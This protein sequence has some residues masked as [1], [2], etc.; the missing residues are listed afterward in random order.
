M[1]GPLGNLQ[2]YTSYRTCAQ[3]TICTAISAHEQVMNRVQIPSYSQWMFPKTHHII[4]SASNI[5][6]IKLGCWKICTKYCTLQGTYLTGWFELHINNNSGVLEHPFSSG[7]Y[8]CTFHNQAKTTDFKTNNT[9]IHQICHQTWPKQLALSSWL[10]FM[11]MMTFA[12]HH[13]INNWCICYQCK[14]SP[15]SNISQII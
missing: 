1:K 13:R 6:Y 4:S 11:I 9:N 3:N 10:C 7:P 15:P 12:E 5:L 2:I 14:C 8:A